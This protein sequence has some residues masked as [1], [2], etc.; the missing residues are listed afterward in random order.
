[1][2]WKWALGHR[3][4]E[5]VPHLRP[6]RPPT[7]VLLSY[8]RTINH[9]NQIASHHNNITAF[10]GSPRW[11]LMHGTGNTAQLA[12]PSPAESAGRG[13]QPSRKEQ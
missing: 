8:Y 7:L 12:G 1:M 2:G 9:Q 5:P 13:Q 10:M 3:G 11:E 6:V 4:P